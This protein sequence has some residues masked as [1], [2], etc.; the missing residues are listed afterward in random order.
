M[1]A[2]DLPWLQTPWRHAAEALAAGRLPQGLLIVGRHGLGRHRLAQAIAA[3]ALCARPRADGRACGDCASCHQVAAETHPDLLHIRVREDKTVILVE[4]IRELSRA[5]SLSSG[6]HG[7]RCAIVHEAERLNRAAANAL[8]KTIEE[9]HP[10]V[11]IILVTDRLAAVPVTIA[12]RCL[13][14]PIASPPQAEAANWLQQHERHTDWSLFLALSAGAPL[15]AIELAE[16]WPGSPAE[17]IRSICAAAAGRSDPV[18]V[19]AQLKALP[20]VVL[21]Q[22]LAWLAQ[23]SMRLHF[24]DA[25][26]VPVEGLPALVRHADTRALFRLWRAARKLAVDHASLN[27]ELAR[28]R[29]ILLFVDALYRKRPRSS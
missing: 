3:A 5:L 12:S 20:P 21:A 17:D 24:D 14:L 25:H 9:P 10:G 22:L 6:S 23:T 1:Q 7:M 11:S 13:Q 28:E 26:P 2:N 19:A 27:V 4:Q 29:L 8:L 15:A 18:A 16:A